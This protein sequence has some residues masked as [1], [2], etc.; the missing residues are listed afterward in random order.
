[1]LGVIGL[2]TGSLTETESP[3]ERSTEFTPSRELSE[4]VADPDIARAPLCELI[5]NRARPG[6]GG[7]PRPAVPDRAHR[8]PRLLWRL[9]LLVDHEYRHV[10]DPRRSFPRAIPP[11]GLGGFRWKV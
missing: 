1:M 3:L 8:S 10:R 9:Q 5:S 4:A 6:T 7:R 11:Q 2:V